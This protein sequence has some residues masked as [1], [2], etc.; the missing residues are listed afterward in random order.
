MPRDAAGD[1][2]AWDRPVRGALGL[3]SPRPVSTVVA[4]PMAWDLR[5]FVVG[6]AVGMDRAADVAGDRRRAAVG[7][8][9]TDI[10]NLQVLMGAPPGRPVS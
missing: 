5:A 6:A 7:V 2:M 10:G 1:P 4:V 8:A 3:A 9:G